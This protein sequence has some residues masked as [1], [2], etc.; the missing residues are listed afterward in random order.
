MTNSAA[1]DAAYSM[2]VPSSAMPMP[3]DEYEE[4]LASNVQRLLETLPRITAIEARVEGVHP[5]TL[6]LVRLRDERFPQRELGNYSIVWNDDGTTMF[7]ADPDE[8][9]QF[10]CQMLEEQL[11]TL[12]VPLPDA[13]ADGT[14]WF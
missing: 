6:L 3:P 4:R 12:P 7:S 5:R 8:R 14:T 10:V 13:D 9:A 1:G 2:R 11:D